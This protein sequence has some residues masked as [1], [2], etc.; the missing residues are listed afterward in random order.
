MHRLAFSVALSVALVLSHANC[1]AT[2]S[3]PSAAG[4]VVQSI[5]PGRRSS[6]TLVS[7]DTAYS[8]RT[9]GIYDASLIST[10][11]VIW[12]TR[13]RPVERYWAP[14][15]AAFGNGR[16]FVGAGPEVVALDIRDGTI[17]WR[18]GE[19]SMELLAEGSLSTDS[20]F[21]AFGQRQGIAT[22]LSAATG[23]VVWQRAILPDPKE[24]WV[25]VPVF[26]DG[27]LVYSRRPPYKLPEKGDAIAIAVRAATGDSL[28]TTT[29]DHDAGRNGFGGLEAVA[30]PGG[31]LFSTTDGL[32]INL[33]ATD[34]QIRWQATSPS[35]AGSD[36]RTIRVSGS[37][38]I[39]GSATSPG[40]IQSLDLANGK[41]NWTAASDIGSPLTTASVS[42]KS[43]AFTSFGLRLAILDR[44]TK[45]MRSLEFWDVLPGEPAGSFLTAPV[46]VG[47]RIVIGTSKG[48]VTLRPTS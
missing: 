43:I 41:I 13:V 18:Y 46:F 23:G 10:G 38:V 42:S 6:I 31:I 35:T 14:S 48:L 1:A 22:V 39:S 5:V 19:G 44:T 17:L 34:G 29:V 28:W 40:R 20:T 26:S 21:V 37:E 4:Y 45:V 25:T 16:I 15:G 27:T 30:V 3:E 33:R 11:R 9:D 47:E 7:G 36:F 12:S 8:A 2:T 32:I 24:D